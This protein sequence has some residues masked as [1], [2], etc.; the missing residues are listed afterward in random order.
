MIEQ[1]LHRIS[2]LICSATFWLCGL[3]ARERGAGRII[4]IM[5]PVRLTPEKECYSVLILR[6]FGKRVSR[7]ESAFSL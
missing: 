7:A 2:S 1:E 6:I 5:S 4:A 3:S